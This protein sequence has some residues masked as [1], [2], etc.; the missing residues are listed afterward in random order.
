MHAPRSS[1]GSLLRIALLITVVATIRI[2]PIMGAESK[3]DDSGQPQAV[4]DEPGE[5]WRKL[6]NREGYLSVGWVRDRESSDATIQGPRLAYG[7]RAA[8]DEGPVWMDAWVATRTGGGQRATTVGINYVNISFPGDRA[9]LG[10][11]FSAGLE[12]RRQSPHQ[13]FGGF[14]GLGVEIGIWLD[15]HWQILIGPEFDLG[16]ASASRASINVT[17]GFAHKRLIPQP[18]GP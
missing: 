6:V 8:A 2:I 14:I 12:R 7:L 4:Q 10:W 1:T 17:F 9:A 5:R 18:G 11:L 16:I 15:K 3:H 13:G